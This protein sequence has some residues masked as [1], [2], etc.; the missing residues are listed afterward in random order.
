MIFETSKGAVPTS[1]FFNPNSIQFVGGKGAYK[2]HKSR[3]ITINKEITI[4]VD[5]DDKN[6]LAE[7][8]IVL[9]LNQSR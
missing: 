9:K 4:I 7:L 6:C 8:T 1:A 5:V 3:S 2:F